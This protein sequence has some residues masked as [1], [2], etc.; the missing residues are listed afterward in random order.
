MSWAVGGVRGI[1]GLWR[2]RGIRR[3]WLRGGAGIRRLW[4]LGGRRGEGDDV[5]EEKAE[6]REGDARWMVWCVSWWC[7]LAGRISMIGKGVGGEVT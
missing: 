6:R 7:P 1:V 4:L 3:G 5:N 2:S